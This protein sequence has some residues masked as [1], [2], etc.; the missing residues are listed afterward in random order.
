MESGFLP[1]RDERIRLAKS[2]DVGETYPYRWDLFGDPLPAHVVDP[3][4]FVVGDAVMRF[5]SHIG[6]FRPSGECG[7][8]SFYYGKLNPVPRKW[9]GGYVKKP[10]LAV[11]VGGKSLPVRDDVFVKKYPSLMEHMTDEQWDDGSARKPST[12]TVFIE[13]GLFK[14]ALNDKSLERSLYMSGDSLAECLASIEK[15]LKADAGDWRPWTVKTS[16][17]RS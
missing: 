3:R 15:A 9:K 8:C 11:D 4:P 6:F 1:M 14:V 7:K 13:Q 10:T 2:V 5:C 17:R 12:F 16:R